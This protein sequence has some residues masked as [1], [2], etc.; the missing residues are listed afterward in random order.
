MNVQKWQNIVTDILNLLMDSNV[1][2]PIQLKYL[3]NKFD[4]N[5]ETNYDDYRSHSV[6]TMPNGKL[7]FPKCF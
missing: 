5:I 7:G 4:I 2:L 3:E 6:P 1:E